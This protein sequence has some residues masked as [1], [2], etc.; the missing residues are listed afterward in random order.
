MTPKFLNSRVKPHEK[1]Q[2]SLPDEGRS[3]YSRVINVT[4]KLTKIIQKSENEFILSGKLFWSEKPETNS[5]LFALRCRLYCTD[6]Q[7]LNYYDE[8]SHHDSSILF[9]S[10]RFHLSAVIHF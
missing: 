7:K 4:L 1:L 6:D 2:Q 8:Y 3:R 9:S 10:H 5:S